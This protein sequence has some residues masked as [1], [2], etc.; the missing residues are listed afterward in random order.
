MNVNDLYRQSRQS[1]LLGVL[2]TLSLG[3][4]KLAGGLFGHSLALLSDSVHSLGD[5]LAF[6][7][8]FAAL[9]W[10]QQPP[11]SEHP[12]G[13]TRIEAVAGSSVALLLILSGLWVGWEAISKLNQSSL[14]PHW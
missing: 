1:A 9:L 10:A 14:Q 5:S 3:L 4:A 2:V 12:Y 6:G 8:V 7:S 11:D 13:H